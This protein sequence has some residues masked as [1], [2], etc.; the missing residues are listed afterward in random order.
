MTTK[1]ITIDASGQSL[2]RLASRVAYLLRGKHI[3]SFDPAKMT[4]QEVLVTNCAKISIPRKKLSS[5]VYYR[6]SG[7]PGNVKQETL[8]S[9]FEKDPGLL[10]KGVVRTMLQDNRSRDAILKFLKTQN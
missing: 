1:R 7:H 2:G 9:R 10:L 4:K 8:A 5:K 6:T 3:P